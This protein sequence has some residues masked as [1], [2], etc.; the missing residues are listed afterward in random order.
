M[1]INFD[2]NFKIV[3]QKRVQNANHFFCIYLMDFGHK[4]F[5]VIADLIFERHEFIDIN[6][7]FSFDV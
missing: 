7:V 2:L 3:F 5:E 1:D 4:L 6:I